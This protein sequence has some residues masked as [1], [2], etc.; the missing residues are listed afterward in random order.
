MTVTG[1]P[2]LQLG[3]VVATPAAL[4]LVERFNFDLSRMLSQHRAHDWADT[5]RHDWRVNDEAVKT[6]AR[7]LSVHEQAG[8]KLWII[9]EAATDACPACH[10]YGGTCEPEKGEW[11]EG[12]HFRTDR[13]PRRL[14]TCFL[15]PED[16]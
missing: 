12:M 8:A 9:T 15:R 5:N 14:S 13:P 6:G 4:E 3:Q 11:I 1:L 2:P 10:G 16:Y 7:V